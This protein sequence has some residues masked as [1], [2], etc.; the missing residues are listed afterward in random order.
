MSIVRRFIMFGLI[1]FFSFTIFGV[2]TSSAVNDVKVS[3]LSVS[4]TSVNASWVTKGKL[5]KTTYFVELIESQK[6]KEKP[7]K[8]NKVGKAL[9][10]ISDLKPWTEYSIRVRAAVGSKYFAW[11]K[12]KSFVTTANAPDDLSIKNVSYRSAE[13]S[14]P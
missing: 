6:P 10:E 9:L 7:I 1:F 3:M 8:F 2:T 4:G 13:I 14:W 5:A 11:S 12:Y